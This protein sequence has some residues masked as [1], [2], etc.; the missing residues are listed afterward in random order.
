M[1]AASLP[2]LGRDEK[3]TRPD[4]RLFTYQGVGWS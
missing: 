1:T 3:I 4:G 2:N